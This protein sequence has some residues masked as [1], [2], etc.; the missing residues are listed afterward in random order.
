P[1]SLHDALPILPGRT[2]L[3][4]IEA[5]NRVFNEMEARA[6]L[7]ELADILEYLHT[8]VPPIVHRDIKP[9]NLMRH[10][11]GRLLLIDFGAV[12]QA[13]SHIGMS[14]TLIGSP[15]YA[16]PQQIFGPPL[17]QSDLYAA[18][19]TLLRPITGGPPSQL[20]H[21]NT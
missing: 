15:R 6:L 8:R 11:S 1:L 5:R 18:G 3:E 9:Q 20:F 4:E 12:C 14:Q 16:P 7:E 13:A 2:L 10:E 19:A 21:N 17:P